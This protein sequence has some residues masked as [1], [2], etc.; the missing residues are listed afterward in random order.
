M[1]PKT[2]MMQNNSHTK[3]SL[4]ETSTSHCSPTPSKYSIEIK[5]QSTKEQQTTEIDKKEY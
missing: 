5:Y 2:T 4:L 1:I 3:F